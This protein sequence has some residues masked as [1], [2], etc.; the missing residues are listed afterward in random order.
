MQRIIREEFA[1]CTVVAIAHRLH[2]ILDF[3]Q[4]IVLDKG[5]VKVI[6]DPKIV[7]GTDMDPEKV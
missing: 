4:V 1:E 7:L 2:T 3:D 5:A 6:G